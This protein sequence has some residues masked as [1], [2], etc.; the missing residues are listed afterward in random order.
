MV[1]L[2]L[3][4]HPLE[5]KRCTVGLGQYSHYR[6]TI[7]T[8]INR[9]ILIR[10][11]CCTDT[12]DGDNPPKTTIIPDPKLFVSHLTFIQLRKRLKHVDFD[13]NYFELILC[14]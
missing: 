11:S 7:D 5:E 6:N 4:C 14:E 10:P 13:L 3:L 9:Y 2:L 12:D 8:D 1:I